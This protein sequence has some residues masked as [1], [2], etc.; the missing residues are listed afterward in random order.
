[1]ALTYD[2][3]LEICRLYLQDPN[4]AAI[5]KKTKRSRDK[6]REILRRE[7]LCDLSGKPI[8][9]TDC[10]WVPQRIRMGIIRVKDYR[11]DLEA[12][13]Q[14]LREGKQHII[15]GICGLTRAGKSYL[16]LHLAGLIDPAFADPGRCPAEAD[17][18]PG[19]VLHRTHLTQ[20]VPTSPLRVFVLDDAEVIA[21]ASKWQKDWMQEIHH[22]TAKGAHRK[23]DGLEISL[24]LIYNMPYWKDVA[25]KIRNLFHLIIEVTHRCDQNHIHAI[26]HDPRR[27]M[28][29]DQLG[30]ETILGEIRYDRSEYN[31]EL[32]A[33]Y[34][35]MMEQ[36]PTVAI[37]AG[38]PSEVD[39]IK[40][41][42]LKR[43]IAD[44]VIAKK[45][46]L[47][48]Y[49][50]YKQMQDKIHLLDDILSQLDSA[51]K[52]GGLERLNEFYEEEL[53]DIERV[54][55]FCTFD[56]VKNKRL[57]SIRQEMTELE[58][59][60]T[61]GE[62]DGRTIVLFLEKYCCGIRD[63]VWECKLEGIDADLYSFLTYA[64]ADNLKTA[65]PLIHMRLKV[66]G[67][68]KESLQNAKT[69]I[70]LAEFDD[71]DS[72]Y[73]DVKNLI[74]GVKAAKEKEKKLKEAQQ[75][76]ITLEQQRK[77]AAQQAAQAELLASGLVLGGKVLYELGSEATN[78]ISEAFKNWTRK[79]APR[80]LTIT[81]YT[82]DLKDSPLDFLDSPFGVVH[83]RQPH[84]PRASQHRLIHHITLKNP[85]QYPMTAQVQI[86]CHDPNNIVVSQ[87]G[88]PDI[89]SIP[90]QQT[91]SFDI[92]DPRLISEI[93]NSSIDI[94]SCKFS[95]TLINVQIV[96]EA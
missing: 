24:S 6:I 19:L 22:I 29:E 44:K 84:F 66:L 65:T 7:G 85:T 74:E 15:A 90:P 1:M 14:S 33:R 37:T 35:K 26:V 43:Q 42:R 12:R 52:T 82:L 78:K 17:Q 55:A 16:S 76:K 71:Q 87:F 4:I 73:R 21:D 45:L 80:K 92:P 13:L 3:E 58:G 20:V 77:E 28:K 60:L 5:N 36:Q 32:I 96:E 86:N 88:L 62:L 51:E 27:S 23:V 56:Y 31:D 50:T 91:L 10:Q 81:N 38:V 93:T 46:E 75:T 68:L 34:K 8:D 54:I 89:L 57:T 67:M 94:E 59:I 2:D 72:F 47:E 70:N 40:G 39:I 48:K 11:P 49:K 64:T 41:L 69:E 30:P 53:P 9:F 83:R 95:R 79:Q 63:T 18:I 25:K 61:R